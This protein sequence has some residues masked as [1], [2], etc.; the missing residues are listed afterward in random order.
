VKSVSVIVPVYNHAATLAQA[1]DSALIQEFDGSLE[2]IATNDGSTDRTQ[3][4]LDSFGPHI[5]VVRQANCG[6]AAARNA[7]VAQAQGQYL[8]FLTPTT[9]GYRADSPKP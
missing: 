9:S 1:I 2:I 8:G 4:V 6:N 7:A 3:E 5:K